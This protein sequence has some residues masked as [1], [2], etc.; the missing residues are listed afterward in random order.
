MKKV[1]AA[2]AAAA[3][4]SGAAVA[5]DK[6]YSL[7]LAGASP[8][9]LWS[10]LGVGVDR[11]MKASYP[12]STVTYQTSGGGVANVGLVEQG[13][14]ELGIVH[15]A[16]IRLAMAGEP[17]FREKSTDLAAIA[18]LYDWAPI[19]VI[20]NKDFA[21]KHGL[22]TFEDIAAKKPPIRIALNRRG[23][24]ANVVAEEMFKAIGVTTEDIESWGGQ[25]VLAA[26]E[27]QSELIRDRRVDALSNS[28]FVGQR[29]V[30]EI[31]QALDVVLLPVGEETIDK[32]EEALGISEFV[33]P[34]DAYGFQSEP[35]PTLALGALLTTSKSLPDDVAYAV[36]KALVENVD[37]VKAVHP[38]MKA[39]TPEFM[40]QQE[41]LPFHPGA[42]KLFKEKG[43]M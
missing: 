24:I 36:A 28:L 43:L 22:K 30:V 2:I 39:L 23:N 26:S 6:S 18:N 34:A 33:I 38:A 17:P 1:F 42:E 8:G 7:T 40:A 11:A 10:V 16:E 19:H 41:T 27:E 9:G 35:V 20:V 14:A 29:S 5:Q 25:V 12:G 31:G 15:D 21:E 3:I 13:R 4:L 37:E 32:V